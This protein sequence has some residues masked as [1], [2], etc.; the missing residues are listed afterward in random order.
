MLLPAIDIAALL[1]DSEENLRLEQIGTTHTGILDLLGDS[2]NP[3][4]AELHSMAE[5]FDAMLFG[6][7]SIGELPVRGRCR[8]SEVATHVYEDE[9]RQA[10]QKI[11]RCLDMRVLDGDLIVP[12]CLRMPTLILPAG[13][14]IQLY[15]NPDIQGCYTSQFPSICQ[16]F[17]QPRGDIRAS[18]IPRNFRVLPADVREVVDTYF[19]REELENRADQ[20][21]DK[22]QGMSMDTEVAVTVRQLQVDDP[23]ASASLQ[24]AICNMLTPATAP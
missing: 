9:A 5:H 11:L 12:T 19:H 20:D 10:C 3:L 21:W 18:I 23:T 8:D 4:Y 2:G 1:T 24:E 16:G 17:L 15:Y 7:H 13:H 6:T 14:F 22:D